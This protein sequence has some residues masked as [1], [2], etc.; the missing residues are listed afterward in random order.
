MRVLW[1]I[2][3]E[4]KLI[5]IGEIVALACTSVH[6][7]NFTADS[8]NLTASLETT[9]SVQYPVC[10]RLH[11]LLHSTSRP[12]R[13]SRAEILCCGQSRKIRVEPHQV[14]DVVVAQLQPR[15]RGWPEIWQLGSMQSE[16]FLINLHKDLNASKRTSSKQTLE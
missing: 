1:C 7:G 16:N 2:S 15:L 6:T 4:T 11:C 5:V 12:I 14:K 8:T 13:Y 9:V 10:M 3:A